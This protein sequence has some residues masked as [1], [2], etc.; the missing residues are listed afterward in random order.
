MSIGIIVYSKTG[1]TLQVAERINASLNQSG[2]NAEVQRFSAETENTQ[3]NK[4]VRLTSLPDPNKYDALI[5]GAPVQAFSLDP[6]MILYLNKIESIKNVP[7][8]CFITQHF[9]K[10][11]MGGNHAM[12]QLIAVLKTKGTDASSIGIVNWSGDQ[13]ENQIDSIVEKC[14]LKMARTS[15]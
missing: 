9:K 11:W 13:R 15:E 8:L 5:F 1:N 14:T 7:T 3:S 12:R 2:L 6:A 4:P 10:P